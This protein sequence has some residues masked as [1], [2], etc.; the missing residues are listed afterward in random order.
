MLGGYDDE[1][2]PDETDAE[3]G[4]EPAPP[5]PAAARETC[6][7]PPVPPAERRLE[8]EP[9]RAESIY[10]F[11]LAGGGPGA[12]PAAARIARPAI[13]HKRAVREESES[14][15]DDER[16]WDER[17]PRAKH[18]HIPQLACK[19]FNTARGCHT[20]DCRF[21]HVQGPAGAAPGRQRCRFHMAGMCIRGMDCSFL[22]E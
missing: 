4:E 16:R 5:Q 22:H 14:G 17:A 6:V 8:L 10:D 13:V 18:E 21:A 15:A 9:L 1:S 7:P 2:I 19:F 3:S 12:R 11:V 20:A